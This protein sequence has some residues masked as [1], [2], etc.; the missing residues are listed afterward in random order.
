MNQYFNAADGHLSRE[1]FLNALGWIQASALIAFQMHVYATGKWGVKPDFN[2]IV[3]GDTAHNIYAVGMIIFV[4]YFREFHFY[5][6]HR[7]EHDWFEPTS[8]F[9]F[10]DVGHLLYKVSHSW[11]HKSVNPGPI[12]GL[13]M[14]PIEHFVYFSVAFLPYLS[15]IFPSIPPMHP[16]VFLYAMYHAL[17]APTGGHDG[18]MNP[19]GESDYHQL[20]HECL[21]VNYGVPPVLDFDGWF[22]SYCARDWYVV[23]GNNVRLAQ[24]YGK[25]LEGN[26]G[27]KDKALAA[28]AKSFGVTVEDVKKGRSI[29]KKA[30]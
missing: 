10:L 5:W 16:M 11:H 27:D 24:A 4:T 20:H 6:I 23:C 19:G 12:S 26:G 28:V 15:A 29:A 13:S 9:R 17:I 25:E 18:H 1:I 21:N 7:L 3:E 14:H 22:G 8:P 2:L 30:N